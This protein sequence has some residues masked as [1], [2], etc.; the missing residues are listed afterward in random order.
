MVCKW[1]SYSNS[2]TNRKVKGRVL[3]G[4]SPTDV[5]ITTDN[6]IV[7]CTACK[8]LL[9]VKLNKF[10][11]THLSANFLDTAYFTG[12][13]IY[14]TPLEEDEIKAH[15][16]TICRKDGFRVTKAGNITNDPREISCTFCI[17]HT[18]G[19][20]FNKALAIAGL[21]ID[22]GVSLTGARAKVNRMSASELDGVFYKMLYGSKK[23]IPVEILENLK[24]VENKRGR[25]SKTPLIRKNTKNRTID[26][27]AYYP[28]QRSNRS[29]KASIRKANRPKDK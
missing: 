2:N 11:H 21:L 15:Q 26:D 12:E 16:A 1:A 29:W 18:F 28:S 17:K 10:Y 4:L 5:T 14:F 24:M 27:W 25:Q 6:T 7:T 9:G 8:R 13:R 20:R 22:T 3:C 23:K 19:G